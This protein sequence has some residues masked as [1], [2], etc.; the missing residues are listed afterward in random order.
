[1]IMSNVLSLDV[2]HGIYILKTKPAAKIDPTK[3]EFRLNTV[4]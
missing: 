3:T 2:S 4:L 1:M